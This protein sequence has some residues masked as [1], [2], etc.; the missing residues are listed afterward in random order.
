MSYLSPR[1]SPN[2]T[3][4]VLSG[5]EPSI[6]SSARLMAVEG[7]RYNGEGEPVRYR[8]QK[9]TTYYPSAVPSQRS[10]PQDHPALA[11]SQYDLSDLDRHNGR[12]W[13]V[14][15]IC[16]N[17]DSGTGNRLVLSRSPNHGQFHHVFIHY[18][19]L[20]IIVRH[21]CESRPDVHNLT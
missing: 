3:A 21:L 17:R 9:P 16:E 15:A 14:V 5:L 13:P 8:Y 7:R 2:A 6:L 12:R 20:L 1:R 19:L 11:A 10:T 4:R 18:I